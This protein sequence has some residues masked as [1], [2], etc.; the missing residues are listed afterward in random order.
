MLRGLMSALRHQF[1]ECQHAH[2]FL[3]RFDRANRGLLTAALRRRRRV[4]RLRP[5]RRGGVQ[6]TCSHAA[7]ERCETAG[8]DELVWWMEEAVLTGE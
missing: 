3:H 6:S 4:H 1:G 7:D 8:K 2:C 5:E